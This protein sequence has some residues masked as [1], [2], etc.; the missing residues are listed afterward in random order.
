MSICI[1]VAFKYMF[2]IFVFVF[3][4]FDKEVFVCICILNTSKIPFLPFS[5]SCTT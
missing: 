4:D 3:L 1:Y 5:I 2:K